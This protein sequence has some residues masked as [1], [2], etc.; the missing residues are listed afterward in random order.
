[1]TFQLT[2][3]RRRLLATEEYP[4]ITDKVSTHSRPKAAAGST[5][6]SRHIASFQLTAARRRLRYF[7]RPPGAERMVSTHSRPKAAATRYKDGKKTDEFQLT[8][9]RRRLPPNAYPHKTCHV[10][11]LTAARRR[12]RLRRVL[13]KG[14]SF[15]FNS[16]PPEG[17]CKF[18][19]D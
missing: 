17:G 6:T 7:S 16:Q 11:Q 2:A 3:A 13:A 12:L 15:C 1:M 18:L 9:A 19:T 4:Y 5:C 8:A 10:F 14:V